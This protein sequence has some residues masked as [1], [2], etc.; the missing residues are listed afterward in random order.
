MW[1]AL[2]AA[3]ERGRS[4]RAAAL[5]LAAAAA[6]A[7]LRRL[8]PARARPLYEP[9]TL[10]AW[11]ARRLAA[12]A[13]RRRRPVVVYL[14]GCFDLFHYGHAN[15]LRQARGGEAERPPRV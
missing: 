3:G 15:A 12:R 10:S 8:R 13:Q 2:G 5:V 4:A 14:D 6:A 7:L 1:H 9:G 11:L